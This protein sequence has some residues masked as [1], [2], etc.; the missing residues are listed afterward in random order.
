VTLEATKPKHRYVALDS[1]RGVCACMVVLLHCVTQGAIS[2]SPVVQNAFLFVDFFFVLSGFVIGSSY[3]TRLATG[4]VSVPLFMGLRLGRIYP[5]HLVM[6]L[7]FAAFEL[8]IALFL[9]NLADRPPFS[10]PSSVESLV[11]SLFLVQIFFGPDALSWNVP[12]WSIAAEIWSYLVFALLLRYAARWL[13][14][15]CLLIALAAPVYLA[16]LGDR[17]MNVFHDGA[18][19]RCLFGFALGMIGWRCAARVEALH[20]PRWA[21]TV[22]ECAV[23]L[24]TIL[25]V[26]LIGPAPASL[27]APLLFLAAVLIFARERGAVSK[28]L[29]LAP[30]VLIG[31]LSYSIYMIHYFLLLRFMNGLSLAEKGTGID[32]VG[33][34][35]HMIAGGPLLGDGMS[36]LFLALVITASYVS[37]RL[38]ELP[39]QKAVRNLLRARSSSSLQT[40]PGAP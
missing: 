16:L 15:I 20:L 33:E 26:G 31:T 39:G 40:A 18:F 36:I 23:V 2:G 25:F 35:G 14:P 10:G 13:V 11:Q 37:Y 8:I 27:A 9:S 7:A 19:V 32:L 38:I 6:L 34:G 24:A 21:D 5:L 30:F 4:E 3:G 17:Y 12:S 29:R 28:L 1:L 22:A